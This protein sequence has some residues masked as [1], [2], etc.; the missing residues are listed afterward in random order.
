MCSVESTES[1]QK[2]Y[3]MGYFYFMKSI[4]K[5]FL[6]EHRELHTQNFRN[7]LC[8]LWTNASIIKLFCLCQEYDI[9]M[10]K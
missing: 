1:T 10:M 7:V 3:T 6:K 8:L 9:D 4:Y 2:D 5:T